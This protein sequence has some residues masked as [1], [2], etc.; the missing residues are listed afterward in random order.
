VIECSPSSSSNARCLGFVGVDDILRAVLSFAGFSSS[1]SSQSS[2]IPSSTSSSTSTPAARKEGL[3]RASERLFLTSV[4]EIQREGDGRLVFRCSSSAKR[5]KGGA[6]GQGEEHSGAAAPSSCPPSG[7]TSLLD[8]VR[9]GFLLGRVS[10]KGNPACHRVAVCD[11]DDDDEDEDEGEG[12]DGETGSDE[13]M[14]AAA[15]FPPVVASDS[16]RVVAIVSQSDVIRFLARHLGELQ[17]SS[18][19]EG[20]SEGE[21]K[22][23]RG[24]EPR[25]RDVAS[26]PVT[27]VAAAMPASLAF[28]SLFQQRARVS[29]AAIVGA[30]HGELVGSLSASDLR[31]LSSGLSGGAEGS[32]RELGLP[33]GEFM[34]A[35]ASARAAAAA[36]AAAAVAVDDDDD[37]GEGLAAAAG[38]PLPPPL[39]AVSPDTPLSELVRLLAEGGH[40]RAFV[41]E[42]EETDGDGEEGRKRRRRRATGVVSLSDV[43]RFVCKD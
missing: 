38:A 35:R 3:R 12:G 31:G 19:R 26:S 9:D 15:P 42:E 4:R 2:P 39:L 20:E 21:G 17:S 8:V 1:S 6:G 22:G 27:A 10:Q 30:A 13:E 41:V 5:T 24:E 14:R 43:L 18:K 28:A 36:A 23:G 25:A 7:E 11:F 37:G 16:L 29:A 34:E 40:H 33:V 32:L